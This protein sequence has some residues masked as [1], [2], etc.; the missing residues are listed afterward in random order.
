VVSNSAISFSQAQQHQ[1]EDPLQRLSG[2]TQ[3]TNRQAAIRQRLP[4]HVSQNIQRDTQVSALDM[5]HPPT[6]LGGVLNQAAQS[7]SRLSTS[8]MLKSADIAAPL[9][10]NSL[11]GSM[12][13]VAGHYPQQLQQMQALTTLVEH[14]QQ[15]L[16]AL[17]GH[18]GEI[19]DRYAVRADRI[20]RQWDAVNHS[21]QGLQQQ[22][23]RAKTHVLHLQEEASRSGF[24]ASVILGSI[25]ALSCVTNYYVLKDPSLQKNMPSLGWVAAG[26]AGK[27]IYD[28][29]HSEPFRQLSEV[30]SEMFTEL[31]QIG[32][33][34]FL[35]SHELV[36]GASAVLR[37]TSI[38]MSERDAESIP[39]SVPL[40]SMHIQSA[41]NHEDVASERTP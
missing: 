12:E 8:V 7:M 23:Q 5:R 13:A 26:V 11:R 25:Y 33:S 39:E 27:M 18:M 3:E 4:S 38:L 32:Q 22:A 21:V 28:C 1:Q 19:S 9:L 20:D 35:L 31:M 6:G 2:L 24:R 29:Y 36:T 37:D 14:G 41:S 34:G 10:V 40:E 17:S 16:N 30:C 15:R